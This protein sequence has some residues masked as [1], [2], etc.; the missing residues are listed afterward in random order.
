MQCNDDED[1]NTQNNLNHVTVDSTE[2][3]LN[4]VT[5]DNAQNT[6]NQVTAV[7]GMKCEME[8]MEEHHH[9]TED[10]ESEILASD[11]ASV[12]IISSLANSGILTSSNGT[13]LSSNATIIITDQGIVFPQGIMLVL[14]LIQ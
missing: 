13:I 1:D 4:H 6:L 10:T 3:T 11:I 14:L 5:I 12:D 7:D 2:N 8:A 9:A